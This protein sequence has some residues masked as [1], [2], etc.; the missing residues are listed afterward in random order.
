MIRLTVFSIFVFSCLL[1]F[2]AEN[3]PTQDNFVSFADFQGH[4]AKG[5]TFE[6]PKTKTHIDTAALK[7][8]F[9]VIK[10]REYLRVKKDI[11]VASVIGVPPQPI[12]APKK[13][14]KPSSPK[15]ALT[16]RKTKSKK[17]VRY[18]IA[19]PVRRPMR[20]ANKTQH[21][22][23]TKKKASPPSLISSFKGFLR[24]TTSLGANTGDTSFKRQGH[25]A[26]G[27]KVP[28]KTRTA[29][30]RFKNSAKNIDPRLLT[31]LIKRELQRLDCYSGVIS[32]QWDHRIQAS[33]ESA[34]APLVLGKPSLKT[35][36]YLE[37]KSVLNCSKTN[38]RI[39]KNRTDAKRPRT[40][41][42]HKQ[43]T[44]ALFST[45][46]GSK[47]V[48]P[49][50]TA[51]GFILRDRTGNI[52][53]RKTTKQTAKLSDS[54][55]QD[56]ATKKA[57]QEY[58]LASEG[59]DYDYAGEQQYNSMRPPAYTVG[60]RPEPNGMQPHLKKKSQP[61]QN[62]TRHKK[63]NNDWKKSLFSFD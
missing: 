43:Q 31:V 63:K 34:Q 5:K 33:L 16:V 32:T 23:N 17:S 41:V 61:T 60:M 11:T 38:S 48:T 30:R 19:L 35:L 3:S 58:A 50:K 29:S 49:T 8:T 62:R 42:A 44:F 26:K 13:I 36:T 45:G 6:K 52:I 24:R 15:K 22:K 1:F 27:K 20:T 12:I 10:I 56:T 54:A 25:A 18:S 39:V 4:D 51:Y 9:D 40:V 21:S 2:T 59:K 37:R 46:T 14:E 28:Q 57:N 53:S 7:K 55:K 47:T